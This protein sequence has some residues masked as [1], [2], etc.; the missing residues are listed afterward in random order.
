MF[1]NASTAGRNFI[2]KDM[3]P[4]YVLIKINMATD[5]LDI[6]GIS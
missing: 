6:E 5:V 3:I 4:F 1:M 2:V